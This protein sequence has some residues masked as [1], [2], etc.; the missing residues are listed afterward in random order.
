MSESVDVKANVFLYSKVQRQESSLKNSMFVCGTWHN[1]P[2]KLTFWGSATIFSDKA[3][4]DE[5]P[6]WRYYWGVHHFSKKN[7]SHTLLGLE[8]RLWCYWG[9][10]NFCLNIVAVGFGLVVMRLVSPLSKREGGPWGKAGRAHWQ[11]FKLDLEG[12]GS[13]SKPAH[14][15]VWESITK[16]ASC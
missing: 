11:S 6:D 1:L 8:K 14:D 12:E 7:F 10:L 9:I 16:Q 15:K 4:S 3:T 5:T 2:C 13:N